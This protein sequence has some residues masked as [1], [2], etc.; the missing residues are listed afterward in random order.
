MEP[1]NDNLM[2]V[3]LPPE[4]HTQGGVV[5]VAPQRT[6]TIQ[7]AVVAIGSKVRD[8]APA[9]IVLLKEHIGTEIH[10][11]GQIFLLVKEE[12]VL[13]VCEYD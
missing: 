6:G 13:A 3:E 7:A 12:Q 11:D 10:Y 5:L 1:L 9:D 8:I 2:V 4:T